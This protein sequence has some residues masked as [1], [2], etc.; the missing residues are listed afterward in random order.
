MQDRE[1][2]VDGGLALYLKEDIGSSKLENI[3]GINS[4]TEVIWVEILGPEGYLKVGA[5]YC[6]PDQ[7]LDADLRW[8]GN[9]GDD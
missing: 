9:K 6:P 7:T 2:Q 1:E 4:P 5:H 8:E 3:K